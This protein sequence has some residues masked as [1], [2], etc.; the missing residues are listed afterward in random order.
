MRWKSDLAL[1]VVIWLKEV[2]AQIRLNVSLVDISFAGFVANNG[3]MLAI[4]H[5]ASTTVR[6]QNYLIE[7]EHVI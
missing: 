7:C 4:S 3:E 6:H 1:N 5:V 2:L